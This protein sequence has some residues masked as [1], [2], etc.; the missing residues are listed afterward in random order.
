MH[1]TDDRP[2]ALFLFPRGKLI[3]DSQICSGRLKTVFEGECL[4]SEEGRMP[5][6]IRLG[7]DACEDT[8]RLGKTGEFA[9]QCALEQLG[10][11]ETWQIV[12]GER[13]PRQFLH[14]RVYKCRKMLLLVVP[15][16]WHEKADVLQWS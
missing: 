6:L 8:Q 11:L 7:G 1:E 15:Q 2:Q 9:P 10:N 12:C 16:I 13:Y 4:F 3:A 5:G 14:L